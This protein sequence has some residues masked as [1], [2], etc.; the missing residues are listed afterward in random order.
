MF[1]ANFANHNFVRIMLATSRRN[2]HKNM[3]IAVYGVPLDDEKNGARN[4]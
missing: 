3:P 2:T 1:G 4:I